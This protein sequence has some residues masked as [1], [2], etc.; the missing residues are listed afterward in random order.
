MEA[1]IGSLCAPYATI[2][3][4]PEGCPC[5][6][7]GSGSEDPSDEELEDLL[8]QAS[9]VM[10]ALLAYPT[11]GP[12]ERT[13][14]PCAKNGRG[15]PSAQARYRMLRWGA[16]DCG[17]GCDAVWLEG[18][19][20]DVTEVIV[21]GEVVPPTDYELHDDFKLVR[22]HGSWPAGGGPVSDQRFQITYM[23]GAPVPGL[24]R[25]AVVELVNELWLTICPQ[26]DGR[27]AR[28]VTTLSTP[29]V[30]MSFRRPEVEKAV[31][32]A[33][34]NLPKV[35]QALSTYN[36]TGVR[37]R[38]LVW[39]PDAPFENRTIRTFA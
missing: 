15:F 29:G 14:Y 32:E 7:E 34:D 4:L 36:P 3:D 2:D 23:M 19:V 1:A 9:E 28:A 35:H 8:M 10:W 5:R 24:I 27:L 31:K 21:N 13:I 38:T 6:T 20:A 33:G 11:L 12:C 18:P 37:L 22:V 25:D 39:S 16:C 30:G 26:G 17:C